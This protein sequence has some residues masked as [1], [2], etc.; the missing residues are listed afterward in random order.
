MVVEPGE[1][2]KAAVVVP[3]LQ[4]NV[5]TPEAVSVVGVAAQTV[6]VSGAIDT[7]GAAFTVNVVEE[8]ALQLE[9]LVTVT[10]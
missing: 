4:L 6:S 8:L 5:P 10:V 2:V 1:T 9:E 3:L 7:E